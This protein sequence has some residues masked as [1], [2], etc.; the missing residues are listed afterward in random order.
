M[1]RILILA[2]ALLCAACGSDRSNGGDDDDD[3]GRDDVGDDDD[4]SAD[5]GDDDPDGPNWQ[6]DDREHDEEGGESWT[7]LVYMVADNNLEEAGMGDLA[8]MMGVGSSDTLHIVVQADRSNDYFDEGVGDL[9]DF[10]GAKRLLVQRGGAEVQD[11]LGEVDMGDG[12][13]LA[14][15]IAWGTA[16]YP[17]DH[18]ALVLW[19]HGAGW[20]GYGLDETS[21]EHQILTLAEMRDGIARGLERG[22]V[23]QLALIGFDACLMG[24]IEVALALRPFAEYLVA[25]EQLVPGHGWDYEKLSALAEDPSTSPADLGRVMLDGFTAQAEASGTQMDITFS[26]VDLYA[27]DPVIEA[28]DDL[29][30]ALVQDLETVAP[31]LA[32]VRESV[33]EFAKVPDPAYRPGLVDLGDLAVGIGATAP[34]LEGPARAVYDAVESAVAYRIAGPVMESAHGLSIYFPEAGY[35][36]PDYDAIAPGLGWHDFL[37]AWSGL[38]GGG[39]GGPAFLNPDHVADAQFEDAGG[40]TAWGTLAP[41]AGETVA[42]ATLTYGVYD[43]ES[44]SLIVLGDEPAFLDGDVVFATWGLG[45]LYMQQGDVGSWAY[46]SFSQVDET[47]SQLGIPMGYAEPG[48]DALG[49]ALLAYLFEGD[50]LLQST[51]YLF[52]N[53]GGVGE[54]DPTAGSALVPLLQVVDGNGAVSWEP[55]IDA[56]FDATAGYDVTWEQLGA[57]VNVFMALT[58]VDYAGRGDFVMVMTTL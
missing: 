36:S 58:T 34:S 9:A 57:G 17:A 5:W 52:E 42:A 11:D 31:A 43:A 1:G 16:T 41:G 55:G 6:P 4:G 25:S 47:H 15:F 49:F 27:L 14:D 20:S 33:V 29:A 19:D 54:L 37:A 8:E 48:D 24:T 22:G 7:V 39:G 30:E 10:T 53:D 13:T 23:D 21:G 56:G 40:L 32:Q 51:Y 2:G 46:S 35:Y 45:G 44:G 26:V 12:D 28:V 50:A 18:T 3:D 38:A